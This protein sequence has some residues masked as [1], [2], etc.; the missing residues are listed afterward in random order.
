M[1][2]IHGMYEELEY[3]LT[4]WKPKRQQLIFVGDYFDRGYANSQVLERIWQLEKDY[5]A[6]CLRGNHESMLL[7]FIKSPTN[8][9]NHYVLNGGSMTLSQFL[10][11]SEDLITKSSSRRTV[12]QL[13]KKYPDLEGWLDQLPYYIE[14][15]NFICVHAGVDL[16]LDD[17][18]NTSDYD[19]MWLRDSFHKAENHTGKQIIFGHTPTMV[20]NQDYNNSSVWRQQMKWGIDGGVVYGGQL[21]GLLISKTAVIDIYSVS[22]LEGDLHDNS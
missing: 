3:L 9:F 18:R 20:L 19:F 22:I 4:F 2:D 1:G 11:I 16:S 5:G 13:K 14:F 15:G 6:L 12:R 7:N 17:W 21:H 10:N 8:Y